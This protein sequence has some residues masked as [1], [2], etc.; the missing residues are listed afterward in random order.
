MEQ[1]VQAVF[2]RHFV[3]A[4]ACDGTWLCTVASLK[5]ERVAGRAKHTEVSLS[6]PTA[7]SGACMLRTRS[8]L[9][10]VVHGQVHVAYQLSMV[11]FHKVPVAFVCL[12]YTQ[13][14][15]VEVQC[16]AKGL[17]SGRPQLVWGHTCNCNYNYNRYNQAINPKSGAQFGIEESRP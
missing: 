5:A 12:R 1:P 16:L 4:M 6:R 11:H 8:T 15:K 7:S 10:L 2:K 3:E 13:D 14:F 9:S 17:D